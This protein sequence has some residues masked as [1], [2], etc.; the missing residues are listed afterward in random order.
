[1]CTTVMGRLLGLRLQA[2]W[3]QDTAQTLNSVKGIL[4]PIGQHVWTQNCIE[5]AIL[6]LTFLFNTVSLHICL[7]VVF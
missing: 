4:L 1:M 2:W 6:K 7:L 3:H 5:V